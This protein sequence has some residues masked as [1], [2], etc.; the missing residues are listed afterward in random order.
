MKYL[1]P[2]MGS[3]THKASIIGPSQAQSSNNCCSLSSTLS[4]QFL[5][6]TPLLQGS[7]PCKVPQG[8]Q[9][10]A[11]HNSWSFLPSLLQSSSSRD[12][13]ITRCY[14]R[15]ALSSSANTLT[16]VAQRCKQSFG[17]LL[18]Q[19]CEKGLLPPLRRDS[20]EGP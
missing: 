6:P 5:L 2:C 20:L 12:H 14:H 9:T 19:S 3:V 7:Q 11:R 13:L 4:P 18:Q 16:V 8:I 10:S 15:V 17:D 1:S